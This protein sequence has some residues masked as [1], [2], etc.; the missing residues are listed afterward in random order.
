MEQDE[1]VR[2]AGEAKRIL[3]ETLIVEARKEVE[4]RLIAELS[5]IEIAPERV[6]RLQA[7]LA[8]GGLYWKYLEKVMND[9]AVAAKEIEEQKQEKSFIKRWR[10]SGSAQYN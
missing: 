9:G 7:L 1:K 3:A 8:M 6:A 4:K 2:R 10:E 5:K